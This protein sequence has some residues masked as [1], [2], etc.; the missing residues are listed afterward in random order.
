MLIFVV[1]AG[2]VTQTVSDQGPQWQPGTAPLP[3]TSAKTTG[4]SGG[5][6]APGDHA[7]TPGSAANPGATNPSSATASPA[8]APADP[9]EGQLQLLSPQDP[10]GDW[11]TDRAPNPVVRK[12]TDSLPATGQLT[13]PPR[14]RQFYSY[15]A[16]YAAGR[17]RFTSCARAGWNTAHA[18]GDS[19]SRCHAGDCLTQG[20][21]TTHPD[22]ST[23]ETRCHAGSCG[24]DGW[25]T[26]YQG[27]TGKSTD[28]QT[29]CRPPGCFTSGWT[30]TY[31]DGTAT[32][33]RCQGNNCL[34]SGWSTRLPNG[35]TIQCRCSMQ[36]CTK[37][38][39]ECT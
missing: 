39:A 14:V 10:A 6:K 3:S 8:G 37:N 33:T 19:E 24:K 29:R 25:S 34:Q 26:T 18:E 15:A 1:A 36:D 31:P 7:A 30:T 23:A 20:W 38:G 2:C 17:C 4:R 9:M 5:N 35:T 32:E 11:Q 16:I 22:G 13:T 12:G 28:T 21:T 27:A